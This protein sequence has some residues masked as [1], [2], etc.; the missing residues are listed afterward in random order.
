MLIPLAYERRWRRM[1]RFHVLG[2]SASSDAGL[3]VCTT[4][5]CAWASSEKASS[6]EATSKSR[7]DT[8]ARST[9]SSAYSPSSASTTLSAPKT[10]GLGVAGPSEESELRL[11]RLGV[12]AENVLM[13]SVELLLR[14]G[15]T[16]GV[17]CTSETRFPP[18]PRTDCLRAARADTGRT[19]FG[20]ARLRREK[21]GVLLY[22]VDASQFSP[23]SF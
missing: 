11:R 7:E 1:E 21:R 13:V 22:G 19:T 12:L 3:C 8:S 2:A 16:A 6:D 4:C 5:R 15:G 10:E 17:G 23:L 20:A 18:S 14:G 9:S